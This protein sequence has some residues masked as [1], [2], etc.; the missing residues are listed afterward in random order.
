MLTS[1]PEPPSRYSLTVTVARDGSQLPS[2]V[3]LQPAAGQAASRTSASIV[4]A[5]TAG[6]I[7]SIDTVY[8]P[9]P[10]RSRSRRPRRRLRCAEASSPINHLLPASQRA[11]QCIGCNPW[12]PRS[13]PARTSSTN[14]LPAPRSP[15]S[16]TDTTGTM[17]TTTGTWPTKTPPQQR[18]AGFSHAHHRHPQRLTHRHLQRRATHR[19]PRIHRRR[20]QVLSRCPGNHDRPR[21]PRQDPAPAGRDRCR[22]FGRSSKPCP[23]R[24]HWSVTTSESPN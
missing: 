2:P 10:V 3:T 8:A 20:G 12:S 1:G 6:K 17:P 21:H 23:Y 7:I 19:Q 16:S 18:S 24:R 11:R 9:G 4:S 15:R 5:P 22:R 13:P 14:P